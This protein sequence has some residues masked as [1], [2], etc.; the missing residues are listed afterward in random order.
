MGGSTRKAIDFVH[1]VELGSITGMIAPILGKLPTD[2]HIPI[3]GGASPA[4]IREEGQL[5]NGGPI[6][7]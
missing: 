1:H 7:R 2:D 3:L 5:Y 4:F 6:W